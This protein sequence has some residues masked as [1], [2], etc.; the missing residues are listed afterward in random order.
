MAFGV[1]AGKAVNIS[2][3]CLP[4]YHY[5]IALSVYQTTSILFSEGSSTKKLGG[6]R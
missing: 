6:I 2:Q 4:I 3:I 1:G 5:D